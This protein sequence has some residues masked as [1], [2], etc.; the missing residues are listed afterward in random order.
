MAEEDSIQPGFKGFG[1][2]SDMSFNKF[3]N[4]AIEYFQKE[5]DTAQS[6]LKC[7]RESSRLYSFT[8]PEY[9]NEILILYEEAAYY[10]LT[11]SPFVLSLEEFFRRQYGKL[12]NLE[13]VKAI[14]GYY[15][16]WAIQKDYETRSY[17]A[18][19]AI[20]L[21]ES[22]PQKENFL[23]NFYQACIHTFDSANCNLE[24][25]KELY[26]KALQSVETLS[27]KQNLKDE[28]KYLIAVFKGFVFLKD[29]DYTSAEE[30]FANAIAIKASGV[31]A[32]YY[33][34]YLSAS[35]GDYENAKKYVHEIFFED[36]SK[37][38]YAISVNSIN[39]MAFFMQN[40]SAINLFSEKAFIP[41]APYIIELLNEAKK[42]S[43]EFID[44]LNNKLHILHELQYE[45][46]YD[47]EINEIIP[48]IGKI[49]QSFKGSKN[50]FLLAN[51]DQLMSKFDKIHE[52]ISAAISKK[53]FAEMKER[54][55]P[56]DVQ[57]ADNDEKIKLLN[58]ENNVVKNSTQEEYDKQIKYVKERSEDNVKQ[59]EKEMESE[60]ITKKFDPKAAFTTSMFYNFIIA[61]AVFVL[62]GMAAYSNSGGT[63]DIKDFVAALFVGGTKWGI[64]TFLF[65]IFIS[66]VA[67]VMVIVEKTNYRQR[68]ANKIS[69][70]KKR[71]EK[72]LSI[73][74]QNHEMRLKII[75]QNFNNRI[76][77]VKSSIKNLHNEKESE[78]ATMKEA[79]DAELREHAKKLD[80]LK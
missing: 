29:G 2:S 38:Q 17:F 45:A 48:F 18:K 24:K 75:E 19:S 41:L 39:L 57:I 30:I 9:M 20:G 63:G 76:D 44:I 1:Q 49:Y 11:D 79:I 69:D 34:A 23:M 36:N 66:A 16:K 12:Y 77:S 37:I 80:K 7:I 53:L 50:V 73:L 51:A 54:L 47:R 10:W 52:I 72:D 6:Y 27:L 4:L 40:A 13:N 28:A 43:P 78:E 31:T 25:A 65:G 22:N 3:K 64:L 26:D 59:L 33:L 8:I 61:F 74:K 67:S 15:A 14:K 32:K 42:T 55:K 71:S 35:G 21:V 70:A 58:E 60:A 46:Y 5:Y 62:A 56:Y 68:Q